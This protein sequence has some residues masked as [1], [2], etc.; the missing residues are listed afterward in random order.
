MTILQLNP[1]LPVSC[2]KGNGQALFLIDYGSEHNLMWVIA[3]DDTCEIWTYQNPEVR[4]QKNITM[5]RINKT[6]KYE[7]DPKVETCRHENIIVLTCMPPITKCSDCGF[8]L[9]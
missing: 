4:V 6:Y 3:I 8:D 7:I 2:P 5:G 9:S 1:T